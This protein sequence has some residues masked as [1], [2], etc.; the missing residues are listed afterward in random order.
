MSPGGEQI[1]NS[2]SMMSEKS[3][4]VSDNDPSN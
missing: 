2:K 4:A 3:S 1:I